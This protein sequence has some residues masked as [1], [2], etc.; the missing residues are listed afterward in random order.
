MIGKAV[1][2]T[3]LGELCFTGMNRLRTSFIAPLGIETFL[4]DIAD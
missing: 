4:T 1:Y 3:V 2:R